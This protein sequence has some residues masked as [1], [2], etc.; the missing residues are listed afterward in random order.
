MKTNL[1]ALWL[2]LCAL[3]CLAACKKDNQLEQKEVKLTLNLENPQGLTDVQLSDIK[4]T[5]KEINSGKQTLSSAVQNN[6]VSVSLAEGSYDISLD[7]NISYK[8]DGKTITGKTGGLKQGLV[9]TG[10]QRTE[11]LKLF[12][13]QA[14][15]GFVIQEIFFTGTLSKEGLQYLGDRYFKIYNNSAE[16]LYADGL[17]IA[18][19]A[20]ETTM[21]QKYTPDIMSQAVAVSSVI[22]VPGTGKQHPV[23]PGASI[24]IS[25]DGI[26][27]KEFNPNSFDL[28][29]SDFEMYYADADDIDNPQVPNMQN[30]FGMLTVYNV[31]SKGYVLARLNK[32]VNDFL[33]NY[34]YDFSYDFVMGDVTVPMDDSGYKIPNSWILDAVNLST[35]S[36]FQWIVTD[37]SIDMGWTFCGKTSN[38][39]SRY[40]KSVRRKVLSVTADGREILKDT[41][42]SALDFDAEV[43]PSLMK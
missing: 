29:K 6:Q 24:V 23:L 9:L 20:F 34:K 10:A 33:A 26:N 5:F 27:H 4:I 16:T 39:K 40:G 43:K 41:N 18:Q 8:L 17:I 3:L 30:V 28:S 2:P 37:P 38:D 22:M 36:D 11:S 14:G 32:D 31:A 25:E 12:L 21:K 42:N 19:S 35:Q 7:G 1:R 15:G 13:G